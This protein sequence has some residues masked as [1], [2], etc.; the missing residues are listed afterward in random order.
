[1]NS[2][3]KRV[4]KRSCL[5]IVAIGIVAVIVGLL[6]LDTI[7]RRAVVSQSTASLNLPTRL[8]GANLS[9]RGG[10][11]SLRGLSISAP[12]GFP[13]SEMFALKNVDVTVSY[14][15]LARHPTHINQIVVQ[16]PTLVI[17][18]R[19][20]RMNVLAAV[21]GMPKGEGSDGSRIRLIIDAMELRNTTVVFRPGMPFLDPQYTFVLPTISL[22]DI[23]NADGAAD[24]AA[25]KDV[26]KLVL[27]AIMQ[28]AAESGN[29]PMGLGGLLQKG[30]SG[31]NAATPPRAGDGAGKG[32]NAAE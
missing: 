22:Q 12:Q 10:H 5:G 27:S 26:V 8:D 32:S 20:G 25:I 11:L 29:L 24:G 3:T 2:R 23:G 15:Q 6:L 19:N 13:T 18:H 31:V 14:G 1:M 30:A 17:E 16:N 28:K 4:V 7:I 21:A 9:L